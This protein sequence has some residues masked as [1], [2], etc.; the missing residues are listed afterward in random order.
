MEQLHL[1]SARELDS[2]VDRYPKVLIIDVRPRE[3]YEIS[4]IR[5]AVNLPY[6]EGRFWKLPKNREIVVYCERGAASMAAARELKQQGYRVMSVAGGILEYKGRNLVFSG[7][8]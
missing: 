8:S 6:Q 1:I 5:Y 4:H 7:Q 3:E 2:Y